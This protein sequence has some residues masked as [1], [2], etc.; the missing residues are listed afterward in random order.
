MMSR[1][2]RILLRLSST[3]ES[4]FSSQPASGVVGEEDVAE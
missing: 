3:F 2:A 4:H 1:L